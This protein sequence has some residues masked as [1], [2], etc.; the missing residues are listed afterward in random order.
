M[1]ISNGNKGCIEIWTHVFFTV[2]MVSVPQY[3]SSCFDILLLMYNT[4]KR[5]ASIK[6]RFSESIQLRLNG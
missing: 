2:Y 5:N 1:N 3:T 6:L 4:A